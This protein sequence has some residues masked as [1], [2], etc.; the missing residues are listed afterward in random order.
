MI[1]NSLQKG[2]SLIE[3]AIALVVIGLISTV[4]VSV[5]QAASGTRQQLLAE[6]ALAKAKHSMVLF[7]QVNYRLPCPDINRDG[8]EDCAMTNKVGTLPYYTLGLES[9]S[10]TA[11]MAVGMQNIFYGVY[12]Q[13]NTSPLNDADLA[14]LKDR[15]SDNPGDLNYQ[16]AADFKRALS[17]A[18]SQSA[19]NSQVFVTG[20]GISTGLEDCATNLVSNIAF[21]LAA[22]VVD[23]NQDGNPFDGAINSLLTADNT[24]SLCFASPSK[25]MD[26]NYDD[27]ITTVSFSELLSH[28]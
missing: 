6:N 16:N 7:A 19:I 20:D 2:F 28:F 8:H 13:A 14:V 27:L 24:G 5:W 1:A 26:A 25:P 10:K 18:L 9:V 4:S 17:L 21:V 15:T 11:D 23:I 22:P 3:L 12:R